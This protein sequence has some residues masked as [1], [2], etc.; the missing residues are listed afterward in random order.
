MEGNINLLQRAK[1]TVL[2]ID[3][4]SA[5]KEKHTGVEQ[6]A[7]QIIEAIKKE[8]LMEG[9]RVFLYSPTPLT[10]TLAELPTGWES[11]VLAWKA[12]R[13]WMQGRVSWELL[14]RRPD[15]LFVPS[16]GL[17]KFFFGT[18]VVTTIH[19][20][21][22]RRIG[23]LYD[24]TVRRRVARATHRAVQTATRLIAVSETT[25][26]D[27]REFYHVADERVTVTHLAPDMSVYRRLDA[28][29]VEI[30]LRNLR[31]GHTFFLFVGRLEKK[32]NVA[33]LI[34]AF[35]LFKQNRGVGDPF[36][37]VLVGEPGY[38]YDEIKTL[39]AHSPVSELIRETGYLPDT[40]VAALMNV[41]TA[42]CFP[43]AYE[44]FGLPLVEA[45]AC[46]CPLLISDIPVHH[47]VAADASVYLSP[48]A[49]EAWARE[50]EALVDDSAARDGLVEKGALRV[51]AFSWQKAARQT[52]E[53]LRGL[54]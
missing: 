52:W 49:T 12:R 14:R 8:P 42:F 50:M 3:A 30:A 16:Q 54:V 19:D 32:K 21:A 39:I 41:A 4:S 5:N 24:P 18:P 9:E 45:M 17:P 13:G 34:R 23:S 44:G 47:E 53:I 40:E 33:T 10:G 31:L 7:Y 2:A 28:A 36:E 1:P 22:F 6:Y 51:A 46:G 38:G 43:S 11:R 25:K 26:Q 48:L 37:L 15:V 29:T 35:E 27:L 20:V